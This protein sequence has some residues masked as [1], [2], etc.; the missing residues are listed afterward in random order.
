MQRGE[1]W[2]A[3]FDE[4]RP[5]VLLSEVEASEFRAMQVVAP[6]GTELSGVA[7][8]LAVGASEGL[9]LEGVLR[10]ALPRPGLIP[11]TWLVTLTRKDLIERAGALS[12]TKLGE[13]QDLLRLGGLE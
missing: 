3:D 9:P 8:E 6:A 5:V 12:S 4:R 11:C 7:A 10:V 2:W 13:L 1:V